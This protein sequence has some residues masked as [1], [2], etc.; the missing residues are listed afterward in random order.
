MYIFYC[1][2]GRAVWDAKIFGIVLSLACNVAFAVRQ[3][4]D[5][6][7]CT[8]LRV[9]RLERDIK[10]IKKDMIHINWCRISD[11]MLRLLCAQIGMYTVQR[12]WAADGEEAAEAAWA[13]EYGMKKPQL[14]C[15]AHLLLGGGFKD[16]LF[17]SLLG[18]D[19]HFDYIIF[20]KWV[21][22]PP[23]SFCSLQNLKI[24]LNRGDDLF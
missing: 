18:E 11:P 20:F 13:K 22:Q 23:T 8:R 12:H 7:S 21:G 16:F 17:S 9:E 2:V 3:S 15:F 4:V 1:C 6:T 10:I 5:T 24:C 14:L 19:S